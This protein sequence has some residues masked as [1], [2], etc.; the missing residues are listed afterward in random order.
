MRRNP[1]LV[2]GA[3]LVFLMVG[4]ALLGPTLVPLDP[5]QQRLEHNL[6]PPSL[7]HPLG[8]DK[9]GRDILSRIVYG[10]RI[11]LFIGLI[12]VSISAG[13][14]LL[15]G[16]A[17]GYYGGWL[18][19]LIMRVIDVLMAFPGTLLAIAVAAVLGPGLSHLVLA[20]CLIGWTGYA[21]LVRAEILALREREFILA[22]GA[23]GAGPARV[24]RRHLIPNLLP[25]FLVQA[26][27]GVAT[28]IVAEGGLSFLGLGVQ[29]PTPSWG[30]ML[31]EG[32]QF[33]LVAPHITTFPGLALMAT[34]L[35]VNLLGDGLRDRLE[36][37]GR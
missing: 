16:S 12:A 3:L 17:A 11:S 28:T 34:I 15:I 10:A 36:K 20:L 23:L 5:T 24:V 7:D 22:A 26:V 8:T 25:T 21:R 14:G 2:A 30:S 13:A 31:N 27:F 1:S 35:G 19:Q 9:L 4:G 6:S 18:D 32:R 33:L 29:P 37:K